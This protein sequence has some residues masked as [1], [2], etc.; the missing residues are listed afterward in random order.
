[1]QK[2]EEASKPG[3][4]GGSSSKGATARE[5]N[6][7]RKDLGKERTT[8]SVGSM[9]ET[10]TV[11]NNRQK[12]EKKRSNAPKSNKKIREGQTRKIVARCPK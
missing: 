10:M 4:R 6:E 8:G 11:P 3:R 7:N 5:K 1:L 9:T 12:K 2:K